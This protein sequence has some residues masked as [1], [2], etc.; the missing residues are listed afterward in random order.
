MAFGKKRRESGT[1]GR[2][3]VF[4]ATDLHGSEIVF[5]KFLNA[6]AVYG[7]DI[8]IL[9]G[10]LSGKRLVPV[11]ETSDGFVT[12]VLGR[13]EVARSDDE[14]K[15]L[16]R[17]IKDLGQYPVHVT[18]SE[19]ERMR[20][21]PDEVDAR[22]E[23]ACQDQVADWMARAAERLEPAGVPM[24]VTG[25]ND[26]YM[27]IEGVLD[28]AGYAINAESKVIEI[29]PGIEMLSTGY[30][31]V[32]PWRCP[33]D[34]PEEDLWN[35]ISGVASGLQDPT[36]AVFNLHVPPHGSGL[37]TAPRLD[38]SVDPPKPIVG[39][40][41][42]VGSTAVRRAIEEFRPMLSLHGHIHESPGIRRIGVTTSINPGSEYGE[43]VLRSTVVDIEG[44]GRLRGAQLLSA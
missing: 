14:V 16:T 39:E 18:A 1:S 11:V 33:R 35:L 43:G 25:G 34:I 22:F 38:E 8:A 10:D 29:A 36:S 13:S 4:F 7:A 15:A 32:T 20:A 28:E 9:G 5:R 12:T 19:Y 2:T 41:A 3:R 26:D 6:V 30:G 17:R 24:Y 42:P 23:R 21:H 31:N 37:D 27:S 44:P 40:D